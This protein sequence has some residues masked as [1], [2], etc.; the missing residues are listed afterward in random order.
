MKAIGKY[1]TMPLVLLVVSM[2]FA[3]QNTTLQVVHSRI[4]DLVKA[5][6]L[7]AISNVDTLHHLRL[8]IAMLLRNQTHLDTLL[9][10]IY[11]PAGPTY[12]HYLTVAEFTSEFGPT[13]QDYDSLIAFAK[14]NGLT[15]LSTTPNRMILDV[16][17]N[18]GAI[19]RALDVTLRNDDAPFSVEIDKAKFIRGIN[20]CS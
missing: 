5:K 10:Q 13:A 14:T 15:V 17:G 3:Q 8:A 4:R 6:G 20:L 9:S 19:E 12:R 11:N 18:V 2:C 7:T 16:S 1:F